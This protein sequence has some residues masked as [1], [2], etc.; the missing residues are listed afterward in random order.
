MRLASLDLYVRDLDASRHFYEHALGFS[1]VLDEAGVVTYAAGEMELRIVTRDTHAG[2]DRD[3]SVDITFLVDDFAAMRAGLEERGVRVSRTL[4]YVVGRTA[5]FY[6]PDGHWYSLYEPSA[7]ALGWPS[8]EKLAL[9]RGDHERDSGRLD[10]HEVVY[11]FLFVADADAAQGFYHDVLGLEAIEGG[12]CRRGVTHLPAGVVKYD[13]G[14]TM[15]TTHA[16]DEGHAE[17]HRV[18]VTGSGRLA[19][20]FV[21]EDVPAAAASL[22]ARGLR[23]TTADAFRDPAGHHYRLCEPAV[24]RT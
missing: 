24:A 8:G 19:M 13:G 3:R 9:L 16:V 11:L 17:A 7:E 1:P 20:V 22:A 18:S 14:A 23:F 21:V 4:D 5:D 15:L 6:D 10:G 2:P 12:P